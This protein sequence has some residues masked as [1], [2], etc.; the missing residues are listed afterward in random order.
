MSL[1]S[2]VA[3]LLSKERADEPGGLWATKQYGDLKEGDRLRAADYI[4]GSVEVRQLRSVYKLSF[5]D[6]ARVNRFKPAEAQEV[7]MPGDEE[8]DESVAALRRA[9]REQNA[10]VRLYVFLTKKKAKTRMA[11][12]EETAFLLRL[13]VGKE[14]CICFGATF[15]NFE[16]ARAGKAK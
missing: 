7:A 14:G 1:A 16:Q 6:I 13:E 3:P 5:T 2:D 10:S 12:L 8:S 15:G 4:T 9:E 11:D